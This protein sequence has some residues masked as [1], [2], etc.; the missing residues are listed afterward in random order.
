M[1]DAAEVVDDRAGDGP[2]RW[3][4]RALH[5]AHALVLSSAA[6]AEV[7]D[8]RGRRYIDFA[9]G[10]GVLNVGHGH[11]RVLAAAHRQLDRL[12]HTSAQVAL[13]PDY[14]ELVQRLVA[15]APGEFPKKAVLFSTGAEA[16]ENTVKI[17]RAWTGRPAVIAFSGAFHGRTLLG[18]SLTDAMSPY[19]EGFG[20]FAPEVYRAPYPYPY[21]GWDAQRAIS[22]LEQLLGE[23]VAPDQVAAIVIEPVLGEGG[24]VA[25]PPEF[26]RRLR[27][28]C[29]LEGIVLV[30]DEVQ[31]GLGR[32]GRLFGIEHSGVVPDLVAVAKSLGG[33]LPISA[34]IGRAEIMDA[35]GP[36]S[37]GSTF[38]GNPVA[39]AAALQV[40]AV[41]EEE[42]LLARARNLGAIMQERMEEWQRRLPLVGEVRVLGAMAGLELVE[43]RSTRRPAASATTR[44]LDHCRER[45]LLL[46]SSGPG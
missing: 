20:P 38:G 34:V 39:C 11:P 46:L 17:A 23:G 16:V 3:L 29:D 25:A 14:L 30:A 28:L 44:V 4:P 45:G 43:D 32:T 13:Y 40:L 27:E 26:M 36:G 35:P 15:L 42:G 9:G 1:S 24:F 21:R 2:G 5:P 8:D 6:G 7:V 10:I 19:K 33:G 22:G 31:C 41:I 18:M 37:L 12:V